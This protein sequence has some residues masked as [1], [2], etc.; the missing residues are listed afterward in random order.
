MRKNI[1]AVM[2]CSVTLL[3]TFAWLYVALSLE[4]RMNTKMFFTKPEP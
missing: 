1:G 4:L 3:Q 2:Q